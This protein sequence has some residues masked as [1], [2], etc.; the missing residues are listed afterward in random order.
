MGTVK[1]N[2]SIIYAKLNNMQGKCSDLANIS[3]IYKSKGDRDKALEYFRDFKT[4]EQEIDNM[5]HEASDL[6]NRD[7]IYLAKRNIRNAIKY[8]QRALTYRDH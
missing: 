1:V 5:K 2:L 8:L 7:L 6:A 4:I 3:D